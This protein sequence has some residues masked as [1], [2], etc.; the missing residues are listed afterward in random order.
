M[1][2]LPV[3]DLHCDLLV[4]LLRDQ[5]RSLN[6]PELA[7]SL[8]YLRAGGV[9]GQV[10]AIFTDVVPESPEEALEQARIFKELPSRYPGEIILASELGSW[11]EAATREEITMVASIE[12]AAGLCN[13]QQ[14][15]ADAVT[16][17]DRILELTGPLAYISLTHHKGNRFGGGN[18]EPGPLTEDGKYLVDALAERQVP[19]CFSHTSDEL[20]E[21]ILSYLDKQGHPLPV[22]A[23]HSNYR[24]VC[25]EPRNLP[26][27]LA[28]A[29]AE[30]GG[31]IGLNVLRKFM[32]P[33]DP[34]GLYDHVEYAYSLGLGSSVV[35]GADYFYTQDMPAEARAAREPFYLKE[36]E[37]ATFYPKVLE[38]IASRFS[39][40]TAQQVAWANA[41]D[42]FEQA[43]PL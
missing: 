3:F 20:A 17:L 25:Q 43:L 22:L 24:A 39:E 9:K 23:S 41:L 19:I 32:H 31:I 40:E 18:Y 6:Q 26:D 15:L 14:P 33:T 29:L 4:Y 16:N 8:P 38:E 7:C 42:F 11:E 34:A 21:T 36:H 28:K 10:C 27:H 35:F 13:E 30:R 37:D 5:D 12:S 1:N 2:M